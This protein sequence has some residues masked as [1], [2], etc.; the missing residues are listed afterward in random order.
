MVRILSV[1]LLISMVGTAFAQTAVEAAG[2]CV[3]IHNKSDAQDE[4][5][6]TCFENISLERTSFESGVCQWKTDAQALAKVQT[7]T[8]FVAYCP[9]SYTGYCNRLVFEPGIVMPVKIFLY[10]KSEQVLA[11]AKKQ[12]LSG[13]GEWHAGGE[14]T[15]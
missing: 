6:T 9:A 5:T 8:R 15:E 7:T 1:F 3:V 12:C 13:G 4:T 2:S 10:D 14:E 11:R